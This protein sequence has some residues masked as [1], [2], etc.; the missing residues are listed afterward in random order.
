MAPGILAVN[1]KTHTGGF[2][3]TEGIPRRLAALL[4]F[5]KSSHFLGGLP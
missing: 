1:P 2:F 4:I 3:L 5:A